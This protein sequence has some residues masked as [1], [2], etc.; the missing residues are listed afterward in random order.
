[1][2]WIGIGCQ[3]GVSSKSIEAAINQALALQNLQIVEVLGVASIDLKAQEPGII[4]ICA[5]YYWQFQTY[6]AA[7]LAMVVTEHSSATLTQQ[8]GTHSVAEAAAIL[9]SGQKLLI[10]KQV[11]EIEGKFITVAIG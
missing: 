2:L 5:K 10:M 3:R 1:M 9:A 11:Y 8:V 4:A 6:S 7:E